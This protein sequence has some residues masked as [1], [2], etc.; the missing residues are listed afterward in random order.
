MN[1]DPALPDATAVLAEL[2]GVA[3][4]GGVTDREELFE[5]ANRIN[6]S[7]RAAARLGHAV[8]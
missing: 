7:D 3:L 6:G 8:S 1:V 5:L 2:V 4:A